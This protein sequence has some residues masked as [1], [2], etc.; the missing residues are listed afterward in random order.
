MLTYAFKKF[1]KF[2][3]FLY[4]KISN[5]FHT[6]P[7]KDKGLHI[8]QQTV[9]GVSHGSSV[10]VMILHHSPMRES[11]L[12]ISSLAPL[13]RGISTSNVVHLQTARLTKEPEGL[14]GNVVCECG[15][16]FRAFTE[17]VLSCDTF[18]V[19]CNV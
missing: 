16:G 4:S 11:L 17:L 7:D 13:F 1:F 2:Q 19:S 15:R 8:L 12:M 10:T 18:G 6:T 14:E 9:S 5:R 3:S